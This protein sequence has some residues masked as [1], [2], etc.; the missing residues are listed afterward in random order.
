MFEH[1]VFNLSMA[2]H[3]TCNI[4]DT[5]LYWDIQLG[6]IHVAVEIDV[7]SAQGLPQG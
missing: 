4:G 3:N 1:P 7:M 5:R 6:A 2:A